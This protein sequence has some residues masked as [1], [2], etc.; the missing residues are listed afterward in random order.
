LKDNQCFIQIESAAQALRRTADGI[1]KSLIVVEESL[2][3]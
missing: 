1:E 3:A 2:A